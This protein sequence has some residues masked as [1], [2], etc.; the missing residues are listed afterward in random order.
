M[1][2]YKKQYL[3]HLQNNNTWVAYKKQYL[4]RLQ[5]TVI[6]DRLQRP[7]FCK[8]S[9]CIA[10]KILQCWVAYKPSCDVGRLQS[11]NDDHLQRSMMSVAYKIRNNGHLQR[12]MMSVAYKIQDLGS[13]QNPRLG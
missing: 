13:L 4:G 5:K 9:P 11:P 7:H 12:S 6:L 2:A 3:C 1:I 8:T 10:Y